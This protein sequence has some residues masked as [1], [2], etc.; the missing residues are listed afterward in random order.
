MG[1]SFFEGGQVLILEFEN[2]ALIKRSGNRIRVKF[3]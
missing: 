2:I 1:I 3:Y